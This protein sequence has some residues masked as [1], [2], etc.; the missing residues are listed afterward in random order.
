MP[1]VNERIRADRIAAKN[2]RQLR[3]WRNKYLRA[4]EA[5]ITVVG[6]RFMAEITSQVA[7]AYRTYWDRKRKTDQLTTQYV[8]KQIAYIVDFHPEL[9]RVFHREVTHL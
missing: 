9:T 4:T 8:N 3:E 7:Q 2:G 6:N 5:F 1:A